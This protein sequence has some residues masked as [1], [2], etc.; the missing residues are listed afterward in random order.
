MQIFFEAI[1]L[2]G[3]IILDTSIKK[4]QAQYWHL[5]GGHLKCKGGT[6]NCVMG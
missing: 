4:G 1:F 3:K 6:V 5:I 2:L